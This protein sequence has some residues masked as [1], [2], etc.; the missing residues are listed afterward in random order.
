MIAFFKSSIK[1]RIFLKIRAKK[2]DL[3]LGH[4]IVYLF[5]IFALGPKIFF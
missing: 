3:N 4:T 2:L 1:V 5:F